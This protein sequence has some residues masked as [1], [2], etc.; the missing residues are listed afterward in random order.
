MQEA[1]DI[2]THIQVDLTGLHNVGSFEYKRSLLAC[3]DFGMLLGI[4]IIH[5]LTHVSPETVQKLR[6][7]NDMKEA[8]LESEFPETYAAMGPLAR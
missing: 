2:G 7:L 4:V 6:D 8:L 3:L 1:K 5:G